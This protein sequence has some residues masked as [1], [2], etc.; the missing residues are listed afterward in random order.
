MTSKRIHGQGPMRWKREQVFLIFCTIIKGNYLI[1]KN[2]KCLYKKVVVFNCSTVSA[3]MHGGKIIYFK[4]IFKT[5]LVPTIPW[6]KLILQFYSWFLLINFSNDIY[7]MLTMWKMKV[8]SGY[9]LTPTKIFL[10]MK[11]LSR[12]F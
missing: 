5:I 2:L 1:A 9:E 4:G 3:P 7:Q 11:Y 10:S 6:R 12:F 8:Y